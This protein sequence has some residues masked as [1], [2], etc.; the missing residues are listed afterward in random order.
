MSTKPT[1]EA[2]AIAQE[3]YSES[4]VQLMP[5]GSKCV[6]S[7][8]RA[9]RYVK[10]GG[11]A[12]VAGKLYDGAATIDNHQNLATA[13]AAI[14]A[15]EVTVTLAGTAATANQYSGGVLIVNDQTGQGYTY[16][17]KSHPAQTSTTGDLVV[18]LED[19]VIEALD[20]TSQC[21]LTYNQH[22]SVIIHAASETGV[23][24]GVAVFNVTDAYYGWLQT[25]GPVSLMCD[26]SPWSA[27]NAVGAS[28]TTD[29]NGSLGTGALAPIG[30]GIDDGAST[31]Y[32][33]VFLTID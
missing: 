15:T 30:T 33:P 28:T 1:S 17:I 19:P 5:L 14:G 13:V 29:G 2:Q 20:A 23:A 7:D 26:A 3:I 6:T 16:Q 32:N 4:S 27:G 25:R 8:G 12:L 21:S 11:T 9:F 24:V 22:D 18:T 31:E 10:V